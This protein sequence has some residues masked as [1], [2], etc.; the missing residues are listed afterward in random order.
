VKVK[1]K[2]KV[3]VREDEGAEW[4]EVMYQKPRVVTTARAIIAHH[5]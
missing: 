5:G 4:K 1:V 3:K 2:V